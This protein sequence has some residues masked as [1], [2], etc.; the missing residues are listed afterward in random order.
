MGRQRL[1]CDL[2]VAMNGLPVATW[3]RSARGEQRFC[4]SPEWLARAAAIP[5]SLS[6]E[7][8]TGAVV[9]N[10]FDNLLPDNHDPRRC[11]TTSSRAAPAR[12][13]QCKRSCRRVSR[14]RWR[15][16]SSTV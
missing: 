2:T 1:A 3:S 16:R 11:C 6:Q 4:Y 13:P 14:L 15:R 10:Y 5:V 12:S 9:G 8:F 7:P